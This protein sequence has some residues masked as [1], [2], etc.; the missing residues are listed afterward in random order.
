MRSLT[1]LTVA[2]LPTPLLA[3][4]VHVGLRSAV[5]DGAGAIVVD[6][7]TPVPSE[8]ED[9]SP[10][11]A[12]LAAILSIGERSY[13]V[14]LDRLPD[15]GSTTALAGSPRH[16]RYHLRLPASAEGQVAL[17]AIPSLG[18]SGAA[19]DLPAPGASQSAANP[20][21]VTTAGAA[22]APSFAEDRR[23]AFLASFSPY[24]GVYAAYG[25]GTDSP[26]RIQLSFKYQPFGRPARDGV[27]GS[28]VD[29]ITFGYTQ[30]I[31]WDVEGK[32]APIRD[33]DYMPELFYLVRPRSV[34]GTVALGGQGGLAH[35]SNGRGGTASRSINMA[36]LQPE[37]T[38]SLGVWRLTVGPRVWTYLGSRAGNTD[39]AHYRG[40][41]GLYA[42]IG[43]DDG[44]RLTTETR[45][46]PGSG[47]GA[48]EAE[49]SYPLAPLLSSAV[50]LYIFGQGFTG[51]GE[52]LL[53]YDR[54]QTRLRLG[55][56]FAR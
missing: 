42:A 8:A 46:N 41:T 15:A 30:R 10:L 36:Y 38:I 18:I 40:H 29:G 25:P 35:E 14:T 13:P 3:A 31:F 34:S 23:N 2:L 1:L 56:G 55:L 24:R 9:A 16:I 28:W 7:I 12:D 51:Y 48:A 5:A 52:N 6:L 4:Q 54:R 20:A 17:L 32:S 26:A 37:A 19:I 44:L 49:L 27:S 47:K 45:L 39:I 22:P 50:N 53:D 11:R 33:V 43:R 21:P